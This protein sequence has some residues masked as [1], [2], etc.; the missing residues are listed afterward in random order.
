M[1][2]IWVWFSIDMGSFT[3]MNIRRYD[4]Y[5]VTSKDGDDVVKPIL[6]DKAIVIHFEYIVIVGGYLEEVDKDV[7]KTIVDGI[8]YNYLLEWELV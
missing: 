7:T 6:W 5:W 2:I 3:W 1:G 4:V 8:G